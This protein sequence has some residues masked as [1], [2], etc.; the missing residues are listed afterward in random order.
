[1][2]SVKNLI[3]QPYP[4]LDEPINIYELD[5]G[6][7]VI[8]AHKDSE[9]LNISTWVKTG[10]INEDDSNT[11]ISHFLEHLMFKGTK[12]FKAGYFDRTLES[13]GAIINAGTSK[14]YTFYYIT[15]PNLDDN[16]D[17]AIDLHS[18]MMLNACFPDEEIG[19]SFDFSKEVPSEKRERYVVLEEIKMCED[20]PW[21]RTYEQLNAEMYKKHSY[22]RKVIGTSE[23]IASVPREIIYDYYASHY[24]PS[25]MTTI[26]VGDFDKEKVLNSILEKFSFDEKRNTQ[27][28]LFVKRE[29]EDEQTETRYVES[30]HSVN[31][32]F[33]M[34]GYKCAP[35]NDMK[36]TLIMDIIGV[37]LGDGTSSRLYKNLVEKPENPV[38]NIIDTS[39]YALRDGNNFY[40]QANFEASRKDEAISQVKEQVQNVLDEQITDEE[41]EKAKKKLKIRFAELSETVSEI[42]ETIGFNITVCDDVSSLNDYLKTLNF[43]TKEDVQETARKYLD[44]NKAT[45][46]VIMPEGAGEN[47]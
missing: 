24:V 32:G 30:T 19:P 20:R 29:Q 4:F 18:D 40:V 35:A 7:T 37:V 10:S 44:I 34:F 42:G 1:M 16:L 31:T 39:N 2:S 8:L 25:N 45:I 5:N 14:D 3:K 47:E 21:S 33:L 38:F 36:N 23:V 22:K 28:P 13:R 26:V 11:G 9:M 46:S 27:K 43:I 12:R 17:V 15:I 6:H 41:F